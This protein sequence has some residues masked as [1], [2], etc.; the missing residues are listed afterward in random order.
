M[1]L[2]T[3]QKLIV[4]GFEKINDR[5]TAL[6][7]RMDG[8]ERKDVPI[9]ED[10]GYKET[11]NKVE[12]TP[13]PLRKFRGLLE[14]IDEAERET[15]TVGNITTRPSSHGR[16]NSLLVEELESLV[17]LGN[18]RK[19]EYIQTPPSLKHLW[20]KSMKPAHVLAFCNGVYKV[21]QAHKCEVSVQMRIDDKL[22][23]YLMARNGLSSIEFY[24]CNFK[25]VITMLSEAMRPTTK[26]DFARI[27]SQSITFTMEFNILKY[28]EYYFEVL[29]YMQD[30]I[31]MFRLLA[32][33]NKDNIPSVNER[34]SGLIAIFGSKID[35]D[36]FLLTKAAIGK[37]TYSTIYEFLDDLRMAMAKHYN[38]FKEFLAIPR[39]RRSYKEQT[40]PKHTLDFDKKSHE[41]QH[42]ENLSE[43]D[44][45]QFYDGGDD[46]DD[47]ET[48]LY[49][50][51]YVN[52]LNTRDENRVSE[53]FAD[54]HEDT[55]ELNNVTNIKHKEVKPLLLCTKL[56]HDG[57]CSKEK[58][59]EHA[60]RFSHDR[61]LLVD[62]EV[63]LLQ[64][65]KRRV[66]FRAGN[67]SAP[68]P[69]VPYFL[70]KKN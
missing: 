65:L 63:E 27:L 28:D 3:L 15:N 22:C 36:Y 29:K 32:E 47:D 50:T 53:G 51:E 34:S 56:L 12:A 64:N 69:G 7:V 70:K 39:P 5:I 33:E 49:A 13:E 44:D 42:I 43:A 17:S 35:R 58:D 25:E 11:T 57:I 38:G 4:D 18:T 23:S 45:L 67:S 61:K 10:I 2:E 46:V 20:L 26:H 21:V 1:D 54:M 19:V 8:L 60:A 41:L 55:A 24:A 31:L 37:D 14:R 30:F 6:E 59:P 9:K 52:F 40:P 68:G 16:R 48:M 66:A 62:R